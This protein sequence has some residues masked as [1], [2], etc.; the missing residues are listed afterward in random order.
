MSST[1]RRRAVAGRGSVAAAIWAW[2]TV[3]LGLLGLLASTRAQAAQGAAVGGAPGLRRPQV[4]ILS[5]QVA[6]DGTLVV[7]TQVEDPAGGQVTLDVLL[8]GRPLPAVAVAQGRGLAMANR[9]T[10]TL[11]PPR[12]DGVLSLVARNRETASSPAQLRIRR[13]APER[14]PALYVLSVGVGRY[15]SVDIPP[16][17]F[18]AKDAADL[19]LTLQRQRDLLY[20]EITVRV[21]TD[22]GASRAG[23]LAGLQWLTASVAAE[24]TAVL[25]LA[26]HGT[27]DPDGL[28]Y[29]LPSDAQADRASLLSGT[30]LQ[31]ALRAIPSRVVLLLDTCHSGNVLGR[32]SFNRLLADLTNENRIVVFAASTGDQVARESPAWRNG[33]FTKALVEGLRGVADYAEDNQI[34]MSELETWASVRVGQLTGGTQ[35]PTLAKPNAAPDYVLAALPDQ[36]VLPNPKRALRRRI[37]WWGGGVAMGVAVGVGITVG[38]LVQALQP[39]NILTPMWGKP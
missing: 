23:I 38:V 27:N 26:G 35:T 7:E 39:A 13:G 18:A 3:L 36:G 10:L 21:L 6:K 9:Y 29:Y 5:T 32:K 14:R 22:A 28:Y 33:A 1:M 15:E 20:R 34:S 24:D 19:A 4:Q 8:D 11:S 16:L 30:T 12:G 37:L 17:R 25:F 31:E 2:L